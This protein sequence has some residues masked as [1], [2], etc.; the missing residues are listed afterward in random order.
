MRLADVCGGRE[1]NLNL[2]R[3]CAA[4]A[5]L[6]SH[7]FPIALGAGTVEPLQLSTGRTLGSTAVAIFFCISGF[8]IARSFDRSASLVNWTVSRILRLFPGLLVVVLLTVFVLGP[9]VTEMELGAYFTS[10][11][12]LTYIFRN[13]TLAILQYD[14]PGVFDDNP[15][16][17]AINGSLWTLIYEVVCYFGVFAAGIIGVF[18]SRSIFWALCALYALLYLVAAHP[19]IYGALHGKLLKLRELSFP[20][21]IGFLFYIFRDQVK[22]RLDVGIVLGAL[23]LAGL[24]WLGV[25]EIYILWICY[26]TFYTGYAIGGAIRRY[27]ELGDY[28]YGV[29]IYAFPSQQLA[30]Y[31]FGD[32]TPYENMLIAAPMTLVCAVLSWRFIESPALDM[33]HSISD[34]VGR[35]L[36]PSAA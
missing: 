26:M 11:E 14:L 18:R 13:M 1:N 4:A 9:L 32:M 15:Y 20:F 24:A 33:R 29:Y 6:V 8:L 3:M 25:V 28:S 31:L 10:P 5:V 27:N 2:I 21:F 7:A 35:I 30:M 12:L 17:H 34:R 16:G 22:L 23:A 19:E 36:K